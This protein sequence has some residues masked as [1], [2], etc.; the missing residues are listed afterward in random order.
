M[1][2]NLLIA[3]DEPLVQAGIKSMI[4]WNE[5][6]INIIGTASTG[7]AAY[8]M[9]QEFSPD[10][11]IT[12]IKMPIMT[13]LE[14]AQKC[15]QELS[16]P[17]AFIILT[18]YEEFQYVK[19]AISYQV[20]D[21]LVKLELTPEVLTNTLKKAISRVNE[22]SPKRSSSPLSFDSV[23]LLKEQFHT[24]LMLGLFESEEQFLNQAANLNIRLDYD[25]FLTRYMEICNEKNTGMSKEQELNLYTSSLQIARE[26]ISK[27]VP[28]HVLSLDSRHFSIIFFLDE[29]NANAYKQVIKNAIEQVSSMLFNY[30]SVTLFA[31]IG[32]LV[33][34]PG[35]ISSSY[36]DAKQLFSCV[37]SE[38]PILFS[39]DI[40]Q[41]Q[42]AKTIFNMALFKD[43][44]QKA[45]SEYD[46]KLLHSV[47]TSIIDLFEVKA[48]HQLQALD[49]ASNILYLSLSLLKNG[50]SVITNIFQEQHQDYRSLHQLTTVP[51]ILDWIRTLRD[52]LCEVFL[53][54]TQ[55]NKNLI[56]VNV[57]KYINEHVNEKLTLNKVAEEFHISPNYL[58]ILFSKYNDTG[59][60]D[61]I[62]QRKIDEAKK[63]LAEGSLKIY[64]I[65]NILGFESAFY[66]S[67]VF[68][69]STG[70]S[71]RDYINK[72]FPE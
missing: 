40:P 18:S 9:I 25:S 47:F 16:N 13:G 4:N 7:A 33:K 17:P 21:Y 27:Y 10:I 52:G 56:V 44:I 64:E 53:S 8:D 30:Y 41:V 36:Q 49:A 5:L 39:E 60:T 38:E 54:Y 1:M 51:Q 6:N 55:D 67:R 22:I 70:Y 3:D 61:Y 20:V 23:Y 68:K 45:F 29:A 35:L 31:S 63:M 43:D 2:Y 46:D 72:N 66:F 48:D 69:K 57:K 42:P 71:P 19:E 62:N 50:E 15:Q 58:S 59:F 24:K 65:S 37:S 12:D 14:L 32:T 26:L 28:C 34:K 11:V